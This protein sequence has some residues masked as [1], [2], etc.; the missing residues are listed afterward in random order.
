MF[1]GIIFFCKSIIIFKN[2]LKKYDFFRNTV[3]FE[4]FL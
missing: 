1:K 4:F 2:I 3:F